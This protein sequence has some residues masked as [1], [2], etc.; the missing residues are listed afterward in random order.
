[1]T[2][3]TDLDTLPEQAQQHIRN[4]TLAPHPE[5][6]WYRR[7]HTGTVPVTRPDGTERPGITLIHYLLPRGQF[8]AWHRVDGDEIWHFLDGA[9]LTL[10]HLQESGDY[11]A[12][13][14]GP[15]PG[16]LP[17]AVIPAWDWQ[18]ATPGGAWTLVA[19]AVGPG[20]DFNGFALLRDHPEE[21]QCLRQRG[22]NLLDLL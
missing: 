10:H 19:C 22:S 2:M 5:G 9:P 21:Q 1:M 20:F 16:H 18:A 4:L 13:S 11:Q 3:E 17:V 12:L 8:S 15:S 7:I 14:L 6:G